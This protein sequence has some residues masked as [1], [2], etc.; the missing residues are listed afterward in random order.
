[1]LGDGARTFAIPVTAARVGDVPQ[2]PPIPNHVWK[3]LLV[4]ASGE[5]ARPPGSTRCRR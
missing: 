1:V 5:T 3:G 2:D 4:K